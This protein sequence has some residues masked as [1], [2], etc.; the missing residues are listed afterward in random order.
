MANNAMVSQGTLDSFPRLSRLHEGL[1]GAKKEVCIERARYLTEYMKGSGIWFAPPVV[2][3]ARAVAHILKNLGVSI[4][5]D[6]LLVG[7]I[8]AKRI[9]AI[10]YPEF[11]GVLIWP[12]LVN[13]RERAVDALQISDEEIKE[14]DQE[15]FPFWMDKVLAWHAQEFLSPPEPLALLFKG[16]LFVLTEAAGISHTAPDFEKLIRVGLE[17]IGEE[18]SE[19]IREL[20][21]APDRGR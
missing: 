17:G 1:L 16:G 11:V 10:I 5:A 4:Y 3:R 18:A 12:E 13:L 19:K 20:D 9:G 8:T 7:S 2:R 14:L 21:M 6:E 15:I